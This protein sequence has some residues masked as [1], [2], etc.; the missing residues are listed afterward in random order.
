MIPIVKTAFINALAA[1]AYVSAVASFLFY[2]PKNLGPS[3][4][5]LV[6]IGLLLLFV[7]SAALT[8][9]LILGKPSLWYLEG[10]KQE[11]VSLLA[12]T[13]LIFFGITLGALFSLIYLA[14]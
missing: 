13:L 11:A 1:A 8:G 6:P 4:T 10:K 7:F 5:A 2:I 14:R 12:L 9:L 3:N